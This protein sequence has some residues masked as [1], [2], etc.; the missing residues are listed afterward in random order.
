MNKLFIFVIL[1]CWLVSCLIVALYVGMLHTLL[2][3]AIFS[4][5]FYI[6]MKISAAANSIM[7]LNFK[8]EQTLVY[9]F[10][11]IMISCISFSIYAGKLM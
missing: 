5:L 2:T 11:F 9:D 6:G 8:P 10:I 1:V 7:G 3:T 4:T